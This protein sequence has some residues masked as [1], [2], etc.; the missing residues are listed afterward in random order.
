MVVVV[1]QVEAVAL[2]TLL[3]ELVALVIPHLLAHH[4]EILVAMALLLIGMVA[5]GEAALVQ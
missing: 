1:A 3:L 5:A 4:K 2:L